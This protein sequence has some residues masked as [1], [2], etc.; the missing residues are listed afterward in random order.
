MP[1]PEPGKHSVEVHCELS[2]ASV[3]L[4]SWCDAWTADAALELRVDRFREVQSSLLSQIVI[5]SS[6]VTVP[7]EL[8]ILLELYGC[9]DLAGAREFCYRLLVASECWYCVCVMCAGYVYSRG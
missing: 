7:L 1:S 6:S 2:A 9:K 4:R 8:A 5:S 3:V